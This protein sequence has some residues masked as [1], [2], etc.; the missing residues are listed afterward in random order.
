MNTYSLQELNEIVKKAT[1]VELYQFVSNDLKIHTDTI[2]AMDSNAI[3]QL[4]EHVDVIE[5]K[6]E[7]MGKEEYSKTILANSSSEWDELFNDDDIVAVIV[8][9]TYDVVYDDCDSIRNGQGTRQTKSDAVYYIQHYNGTDEFVREGYKR[10]GIVQ[11][12]CNQPDAAGVVYEET[13]K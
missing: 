11:V 5:A 6:V 3:E 8:T 7:L 12:E 10:G 2:V 1:D 4:F 9:P 13:V